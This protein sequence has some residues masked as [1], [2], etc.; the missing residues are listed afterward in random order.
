MIIVWILL[1]ILAANT[2]LFGGLL[3]WYL[4]EKRREKHGK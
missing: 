3:T 4:V 2:V 1:G